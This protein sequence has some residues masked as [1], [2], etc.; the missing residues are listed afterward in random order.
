MVCVSQTYRLVK[1]N[2]SFSE[3]KR[4]FYFFV[5]YDCNDI[6]F[7]RTVTDQET[8]DYSIMNRWL[9]H[10]KKKLSTPLCLLE[11]IHYICNT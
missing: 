6:H 11:I 10:I 2:I 9:L 1:P 7:L 5:L 4:I 3:A 8:I